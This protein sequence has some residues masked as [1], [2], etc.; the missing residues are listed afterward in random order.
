MCAGALVNA[1]I[2]RLV[3]GCRDDKA[4]AVTSLFAI[5]RHPRLKH[6]FPIHGGVLE[7]ECAARLRDFFDARRG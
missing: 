5:G 6:R 1:R 2:G 7:D 4:G 3:F